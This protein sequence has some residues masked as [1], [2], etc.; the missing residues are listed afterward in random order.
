[1]FVFVYFGIHSKVPTFFVSFNSMIST[2]EQIDALHY[3]KLLF[4]L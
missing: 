2:T 1:M 3:N 4:E